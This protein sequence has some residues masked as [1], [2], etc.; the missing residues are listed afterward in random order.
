MRS[1]IA[2]AAGLFC[3]GGLC[4]FAQAQILTGRID[5][6]AGPSVPTFPT[7][8]GTNGFQLAPNANGGTIMGE[9]RRF[10]YG[11]RVNLSATYDDNIFIARSNRRG[12]WLFLIEPGIFLGW[13]NVAGGNYFKLDYAPGFTFFEKNSDQNN[14][15][16]RF[17]LEGGYYFGKLSLRIA[18]SID[19]L[20]GADTQS[21][22]RVSRNIYLTTL[23]VGYAIT[24]KTSVDLGFTYSLNDYRNQIDN[25][26]YG[27]SVYFNYTPGG[28]WTYGLGG[29]VNHTTVSGLNGVD[30][31][32]ENINFRANYQA[33]GK[34]AFNAS[35][36]VEIRQFGGSRSN[37]VTPLFELGAI[38]QP[39][40]G[41]TV[42]LRAGRRTSPSSV[43][44][45]QN[46]IPTN[47]T[48]SLRQ[49]F[50]QRLFFSA[51][52][53]F[54][55]SSYY[56]TVPSSTGVVSG[57]SDNYYTVSLGLDY[58]VREGLSVG[59]FYT[60]RENAGNSL[61]QPFVF[62]NNQYGARVSLSF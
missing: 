3:A 38:Y 11:F 9:Y 1:L 21:G 29:G 4:D 2:G 12:D 52:V 50:I 55:N 58:A 27:G 42:T 10:R 39:F 8:Y 22:N 30:Q 19:V 61:S 33:T 7:A 20:H 17:R 26:T 43:L 25:S 23:G 5:R 62:S 36:G 28:K 35:V 6:V 54:E 45:G 31:N 49:R 34:L 13:G 57:R 47:F 15:E 60:H 18:Q 53:G 32:S 14:L 40:D 24:G 46:F 37:E 48:L 59:A 51:S 41:T 44:G 56:A 16:H